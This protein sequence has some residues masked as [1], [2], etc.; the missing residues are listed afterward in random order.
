LVVNESVALLAS[1][2]VA[3][4]A[5]ALKFVLASTPYLP[6]GTVFQVNVTVLLV[7]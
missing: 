1:R 3:I 5:H 4:A 7:V 2:F 6:P